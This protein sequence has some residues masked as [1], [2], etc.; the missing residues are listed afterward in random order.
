[1]RTAVAL[2]LLVTFC[3]AYANP[4][5]VLRIGVQRSKGQVQDN[6][7]QLDRLRNN[8]AQDTIFKIKN[9]W[10]EQMRRHNDYSN[11]TIDAIR[12]EVDAAKGEDKNAQP[13]YDTASNTLRNIWNTA[14]S[15]AQRCVDTAES[16]IKS[17]L[18]FVDNLIST[19]RTLMVELDGIFLNCF[20]NDIFQVQRC[21]ALKLGTANVNAR[22]LQSKANSAKFTA[23]SASNNI[24][25]QGNNCVYNVYSPA[26]SQITELRLAATRCLK[27]L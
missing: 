14:S 23:T 9:N 25:L 5:D 26:F 21:V 18:G 22:D 16:S 19:G 3:T 20:G 13:C 2:C 12:K 4:L 15:D 6:I 11:P 1:M 27:A 24:V 8:V 10:I 17:E 7:Q